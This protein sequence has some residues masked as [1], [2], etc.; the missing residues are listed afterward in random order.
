MNSVVRPSKFGVPKHVQRSCLNKNQRKLIPKRLP[1]LLT[2][3][4]TLY[5]NQ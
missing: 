4:Q 1:A 2:E 5:T 3:P